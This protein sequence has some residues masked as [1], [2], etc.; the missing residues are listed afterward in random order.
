MKM[1]RLLVRCLF[2]A[3]FVFMY[4]CQGKRGQ[5][6]QKNLEDHRISILFDSD[7]NNE[8]DDQQA[9]AYILFNS[10]VFELVGITVNRTKSGGDVEGHYAE[11]DRIVRLCK[12]ED[13]VQIY[14]GVNGSYNEILPYLGEEEFDGSEAVNYIIHE[15][16]KE[17]KGK[18]VLMP[19]GKLTNVTLA[20]QKDPSIAPKV[21]I[22]W[23]G[24]NYP[25]SGEYNFDND[26]SALNPILNMDVEFEIAVV[27][28]GESTGTAAVSAY[29]EDFRKIMPGLGPESNE[30]VEGRHG[31]YFTHFGD[32]GLELFE[33]YPGS[34][35]VRS[36]FDMAAVA[37]V[38]NPAWA[39]SIEV[40]A[41]IFLD[42]AFVDRPDNPR[43]ILIW[44]Q[45][46]QDAIMED[47]YASMDDYKLSGSMF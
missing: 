42:G 39:K 46:D 45:F 17:R 26:T 15:A 12:S 20:L 41:P 22:V 31:G 5:Q 32:Y 36:L 23:L 11:A 7:T 2:L 10:D 47:F 9:L 6:N 24:S 1:I 13:K 37:I 43:K 33:K 4:S 14:K 28:S 30:P 18:L 25:K 35:T 27:R 3:S 16:H 40:P 8:L 34:P 44:E 29:L 38:K 21:R 19:V